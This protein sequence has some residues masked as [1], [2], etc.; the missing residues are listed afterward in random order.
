MQATK[1]GERIAKYIARAGLC[2]RREAERLIFAGRVSVNS[3][4]LSTPAFFVEPHHT[5]MVDGKPLKSAEPTELWRYHK[6]PG[7][8]TT[9]HDPQNRTTVFEKIPQSLGRV[10]SVGRLDLTSEGLLLLTND[11]KLS[12]LL[13]QSNWIRKYRVRVFGQPKNRDIEKLSEGITIN[14]I[15]YSPI[16]ARIDSSTAHNVWLTI[17]LQEGKNREIRK[18]LE[19]LGCQVNRLIRTAYGP[20]Q[21]GSMKREEIIRIPPKT[22]REQLSQSGANRRR[23]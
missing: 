7:Y 5:I 22:L 23:K 4:K 14:N 1:T 21:L 12:R 6:P 18:V 16:E 3:E 17:N 19:H 11:G 2:S 9:H 13:E 20:F 8:I 10:I 15:K